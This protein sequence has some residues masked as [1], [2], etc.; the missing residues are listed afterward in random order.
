LDDEELL[1]NYGSRLQSLTVC[2]AQFKTILVNANT[3]SGDVVGGDS[4]EGIRRGDG[5]MCRLMRTIEGRWG[6]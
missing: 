6:V 3:T 1:S 5:E 4:N 2:G